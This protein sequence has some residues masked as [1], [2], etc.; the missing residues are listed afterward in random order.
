M[1]M[2]REE[3][4]ARDEVA[5][6]VGKPA[7]EIWPDLYPEP[8]PVTAMWVEHPDALQE[9]SLMV[10][11]LLGSNQDLLKAVHSEPVMRRPSIEALMRQYTS[12]VDLYSNGFVERTV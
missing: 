1:D 8:S 9:Q 3:L 5:A 4:L 2:E 6:I 7:S 11:G 10:L 12:A